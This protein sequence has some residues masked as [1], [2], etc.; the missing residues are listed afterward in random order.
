MSRAGVK[1]SETI[2]DLPPLAPNRGGDDNGVTTALWLAVAF[3]ISLVIGFI[4]MRLPGATVK[5]NELSIERTLFTVINAATGTGFQQHIGLEQY[6]ALGKT[7]IVLLMMIGTIIT[8][9]IGGM[10]VV[11]VAGMDYSDAQ[12]IRTTVITY[13]LSVFAGAALLA[14]PQRGLIPSAVQAASAF[15]NSGLVLGSVPPLLDWR[16]HLVLMPLALLGGLGIPVILDLCAFAFG[17]GQPSAHSRIVLTLVAAVYLFG[18]IAC[19]PWDAP[20]KSWPLALATGSLE[21]INTR[22][23]GLPIAPLSTFSRM[24]Q[25]LIIGLMIVGAAP[26]GATGGLKVTALYHVHHGTRRALRRERA[27]RITGIA[28]LWILSYFAIVAVTLLA[29]LSQQPELPPDRLLFIAISAVSL[30]GLSHEPISMTG[31]GLHVL[32]L[33][34]LLGRIVPWLILWWTATT[35]TP[36][37]TDAAIG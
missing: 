11:R 4:V 6:G 37:E 1:P 24:T 5:G 29:L 23:A 12:I 3:A 8:L 22:S 21:S 2:R 35:L 18:L 30:V 14:E 16:T 32:A 9:I 36:E 13:V 33:A 15:G 31:P 17:R 28:A 20:G 26:G 25:W 34:M 19:V 10:A 7:C 27:S